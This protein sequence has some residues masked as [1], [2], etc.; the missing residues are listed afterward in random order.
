MNANLRNT[1]TYNAHFP[2]SSFSNLRGQFEGKRDNAYHTF[3]A[4]GLKWL[5]LNLELWARNSAIDWA[6]GV[7]A[8]NPD[9]NVIVITHMH[10]NGDGSISTSNGGYGNNSPQYVYDNLLKKYA[11]VR[12]VFSGHVGSHAYR[13]NTGNNGNRIYQFLNTFHDGSTNPTRIGDRH[14]GQHPEHACTP[15]TTTRR[16]DA[17][18]TVSNITWV[19]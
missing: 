8:A 10:L 7:L 3:E 11:N 6:N 12:L 17:T 4:G 14:R 9:H 19:R 5:V 1:T 13:E 16:E 18:R 2:A 15:R